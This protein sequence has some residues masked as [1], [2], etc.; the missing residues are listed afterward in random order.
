MVTEK[1]VLVRTVEEPVLD[2][3]RPGIR[4]SLFLVKTALFSVGVSFPLQNCPRQMA[5]RL[6][7]KQYSEEEILGRQKLPAGFWWQNLL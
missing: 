6:Q 4:K 3:S 7:N 2:L 1:V 5:P